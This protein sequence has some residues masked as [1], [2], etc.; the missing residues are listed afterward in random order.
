MDTGLSK[1]RPGD[2][3]PR[4][5]GF[6]WF[7]AGNTETNDEWRHGN[8]FRQISRPDGGGMSALD[9]P[10]EFRRGLARFNAIYAEE[11][12]R[13]YRWGKT[14]AIFEDEP[15]EASLVELFEWQK[16]HF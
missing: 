16:K 10:E 1:P 5:I 12:T 14:P 2:R 7:P 13:R 15:I 8:V 11:F 9:D 6:S 4:E 3:S